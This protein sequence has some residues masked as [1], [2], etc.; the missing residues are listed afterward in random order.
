[1]MNSL[2]MTLT[3]PEPGFE[4]RRSF[5]SSIA[6]KSCYNCDPHGLQSRR[7]HP[8]SPA[9]VASAVCAYVSVFYAA[10]VR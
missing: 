7:K 8:G 5:L 9:A 3:H 2:S 4:G 10:Y 1:M 6:Q